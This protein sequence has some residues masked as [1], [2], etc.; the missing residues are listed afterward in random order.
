M[1]CQA[2]SLSK[3]YASIPQGTPPVGIPWQSPSRSQLFSFS[4]P[5][6]LHCFLF[7]KGFLPLL[8]SETSQC[9][10]LGKKK[11]KRE[12]TSCLEV[13]SDSLK[14]AKLLCFCHINNESSYSFRA[15]KD[16]DLRGLQLS[17]RF[18][19]FNARGRKRGT[20]QAR[21]GVLKA[22]RSFQG[23]GQGFAKGAGV[24]VTAVGISCYSLG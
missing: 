7:L 2:R 20:G 19:C 13:I 17:L 11:K 5:I 14:Y 21:Q 12:R 18:F 3:G 16:V 23:W 22:S 8:N 9:V 4:P 6:P 24:L 1:W 10:L 15:G